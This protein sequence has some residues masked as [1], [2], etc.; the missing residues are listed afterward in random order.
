MKIVSIVWNINRHLSHVVSLVNN[1]DSKRVTL[2]VLTQ[3]HCRVRFAIRVT[4]VPFRDDKN[5]EWYARQ[6]AKEKEV[7]KQLA[8]GINPA[9]GT[10]APL[11]QLIADGTQ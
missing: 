7:K 9:P 5:V 4:L 2:T 3:T 8:N 1:V 6:C 11:F 10:I